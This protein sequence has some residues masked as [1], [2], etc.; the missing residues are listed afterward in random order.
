M[1]NA[2]EVIQK[3]VPLGFTHAI[4]YFFEDELMTVCNYSADEGDME[5]GDIIFLMVG[6][7]L[8]QKARAACSTLVK[9]ACDSK[10]ILSEMINFC[11]LYSMA[12]D[13]SIIGL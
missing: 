11:P 7:V 2:V 8:W 3:L 1:T 9:V 6:V 4:P 13:C 10:L 12:E 5:G